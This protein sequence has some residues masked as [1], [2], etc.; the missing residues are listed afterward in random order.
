[1]LKKFKDG[2]SVKKG[3]A[4]A[5]SEKNDCVVRAL[6]HVFGI[7]YNQSHKFCK[8]ELGREDKRGAKVQPLRK[9]TNYTF[10]KE[11]G[12]QLSLFEGTS[13][14]K[15][16]KHLGICPKLG[17]ELKN[18]KYKHKAV[19]YTVKEFIRRYNTGTYLLIVPKHALAV[20]DGML[21]DNKN[22]DAEG[23]RRIVQEA[24]YI[25]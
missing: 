16:I 14:T 12:M 24:Y 11:A 13:T 6:A 23:Y 7:N 25:N 15:R 1:M 4:L 3:S 19:A 10:P 20:K 21:I 8:E 9:I 2:Y 5:T 22:Y 17:G 18:P